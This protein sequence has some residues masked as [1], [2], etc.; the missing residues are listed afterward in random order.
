MQYVPSP[1]EW[2]REQVDLYEQSDGEKGYDIRGYPCVIVTHVGRRSGA[3]R[4][5]PL[6]RV[7]HGGKYVLVASMGGAPA[8]PQWAHNLR[9]EPDIAVRDKA[10]VLDVTA[11]EV[12]DA[13]EHAAVWQV[14]VDTFPDY[15]DYQGKTA[16]TIP[17]FVC[18]PR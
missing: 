1:S 4:K 17:V 8:D 7:V 5:S 15:A 6:I 2:V 18:E 10:E 13:D 16:R 11:R 14:C 12:T 9:A 3:I